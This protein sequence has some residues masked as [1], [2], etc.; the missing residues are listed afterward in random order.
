MQIGTIFL[1]ESLAPS[2]QNKQT[3]YVL[4]FNAV[5]SLLGI[6]PEGTPLTIWKHICEIFFIA[7]EFVIV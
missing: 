5:M 7:V 6:Y 1:E 3:T 2:E 4:V